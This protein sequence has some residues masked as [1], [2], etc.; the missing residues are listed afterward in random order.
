MSDSKITF[1]AAVSEQNSFDFLRLLFAFAVF[2]S[3]FG[4]LT[5]ANIIFPISS[6]QGVAGFFIISG[7]LITQSYYRS[8]GL[9]DYM[10][11]RVRRI[12]PAY[13]LVVVACAVF[14][15]LVSSLSFSEYFGSKT[16]FKYVAANLSFLNFIQ[17]DLPGVFTA[18][19][20][21]YINGAL[22][23]IKVEL[24]LYAFIPLL[25]LFL[26][27][28]PF[29]VLTGVY[30]ASFIF[31]YGMNYLYNSSGKEFYSILSRQ[32]VGQA[33]YFISGIILLFYFDFFRKNIKYFLP[34]AAIIFIARYSFISKYY[35]DFQA[36]NIFINILY[37]FSF[38]VLIIYF[39]YYFKKLA[40]FS[41]Y[42]DFSYGMYLFHYPVIQTMIYLG[43]FK[44]NPA[45]LFTVCFVIVLSLSCLSWHLLEK[46]F[47]R[48]KRRI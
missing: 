13:V 35:I 17:P 14:L 28:K 47:L 26:N 40:C 2:I 9:L 10:K 12:V 23:T 4:I 5:G 30:V 19:S 48:H 41:I 25:T 34:L 18:N 43:W 11:K 20:Y 27:R 37:P 32:F 22:W 33:R 42:G 15:S 46:H 36:A 44:E 3:H 7:F 1:S 39:A 8:S 29:F 45:L 38:A 24:A 16:F 31:V 21:P 6:P